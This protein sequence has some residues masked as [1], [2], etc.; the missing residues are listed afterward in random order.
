M[1]AQKCRICRIAA[2]LENIQIKMFNGHKD[3]MQD[4]DL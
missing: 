2:G 3:W 4:A 1:K